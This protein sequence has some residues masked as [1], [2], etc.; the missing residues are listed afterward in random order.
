MQRAVAILVATL[1]HSGLES[2]NLVA[3]NQPKDGII[4]LLSK[5]T[6]F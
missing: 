3:G 2:A 6:N 4:M 5:K 1:G